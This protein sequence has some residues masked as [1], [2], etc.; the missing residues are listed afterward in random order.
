MMGT[1][2]S[3]GPRYA[4]PVCGGHASLPAGRGIRC[5]GYTADGRTVCTR[6]P[7]PLE[8]EGA[9]GWAHY[10]GRCPCGEVHNSEDVLTPEPSLPTREPSEFAREVWAES[11]TIE[12]THASAYLVSRGITICAPSLRFHLAL[13]HSPSSLDLPAMIAGVSVWPEVSVRA[14]HRTYL[15]VLRPAKAGVEPAK[16][17]LGPCSR[18]AVRLAPHGERLA[19]SEGIETGLAFQEATAIPTWACLSTSGLRSI[20]V[21]P[22][23]EIVIAAD[24]DVDGIRAAESAT[25]R[26][27]SEGHR[28]PGIDDGR[29]A[30]LTRAPC[31]LR[32]WRALEHLGPTTHHAYY[33]PLARMD[34]TPWAPSRLSCDGSNTHSRDGRKPE[35]WQ[36][37]PPAGRDAWPLPR[38][39]P[40]QLGH[41]AA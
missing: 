38:C 25:D 34:A 20:V 17:M 11:T 9:G 19:L 37:I 36:A 23:V 24:R 21:P 8:A 7:S 32:A 12:G 14:V 33:T 10:L 29:L 35:A 2:Q 26:L 6:E 15:D 13:R 31:L 4:C 1:L 22:D 41:R 28:V 3:H 30:I 18:G 5:Y 27:T 39:A 16:M 40:V